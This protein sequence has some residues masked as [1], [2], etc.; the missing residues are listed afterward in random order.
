MSVSNPFIFGGTGADTTALFLKKYTDSFVEAPRSSVFLWD[1]GVNV[2]N[3]RTVENGKSH[4]FLMNGDVP[5]SEEF[6]PGDEMLGQAGAVDEGTITVDKYLVAHKFIGQDQMR[7]SHFELLPKLA[8]QHKSIIERRYDRRLFTLGALAARTAAV[9]KNG[10]TIHNGGN[11]VTRSGTAAVATAYAASSTGAANFSTDL[12]SLGYQMDLDNID[13]N[14]RFLWLTPYMRSVV[15]YDT[16]LKIFSRDFINGENQIMK[17]QVRELHGFQIM[18]FPNT[19]TSGGPFPDQNLQSESLSKYNGNFT[20][21]AADGTPVALALC[22]GMAG[23]AA[24]GVVNYD[25][26]QNFVIYQQEKLGWLVGSY[27]LCG[28][29]QMHPWCAGSV[30]VIV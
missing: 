10:L 25:S 12:I 5:D 8:K 20:I 16:S 14:Q 30:E 3:R 24:V 22:G 1:S 29:G 15:Q 27:I 4:Q 17:R 9:T 21:Q 18:D 11:R 28:A 7:E 19:T 26:L 13:P 6:N 23:E 2:V